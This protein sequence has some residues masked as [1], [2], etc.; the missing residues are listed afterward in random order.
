MARLG[1]RVQLSEETLSGIVLAA[2]DDAV[3]ITRQ[4]NLIPVLF[5]APP[6][7]LIDGRMT[8]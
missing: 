7:T 8:V 2:L 1:C 5:F 6:S 3:P 4:V